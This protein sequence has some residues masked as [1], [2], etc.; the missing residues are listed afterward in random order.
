MKKKFLPFFIIFLFT[1]SYSYS[2]IPLDPSKRSSS[3]PFIAGDTFRAFCDFIIDETQIPFDPN[4]VKNG[5]TIFLKHN[6]TFLDLF[7]KNIHPFI[8]NKYILITH[9]GLCRNLSPYIKYLNDK[10]I[11]AWL[12]K[13]VYLSHPKAQ[14]IPVGIANNHWS[15]GNTSILR[16]IIE[17]P[18]QK[19]KLCYINFDLGPKHHYRNKIRRNVLK[20]FANK[21]FCYKSKRKNFKEYIQD[22][23][24]SKFVVSPEGEGIDCH[25]TWESILVG[26]I[27]IIS[28]S[29]LDPMFENL[30]VLITKKWENITKEFLLKKYKEMSSKKYN[31]EKLYANFWFD[32][33]IKI[34]KQIIQNESSKK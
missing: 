19:D 31:L 29:Q 3:Y 32:K 6:K 26:S 16:S 4:L 9:N 11:V 21:K 5:N 20:V 13:N 25:R 14:C 1:F 23:S 2:Q 15:H 12:G 24:R 17:N 33:I 30:P 18:L 28:T 10:N 34:K 8:K 27:P 22:L 7:F